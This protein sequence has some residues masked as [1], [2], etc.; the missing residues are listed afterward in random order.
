MHRS[1]QY[2]QT[3]S[4]YFHLFHWGKPQFHFGQADVNMEITFNDSFT[5]DERRDLSL[6]ARDV[7][8]V[9][10]K[11][12]PG[13]PP[14]GIRPISVYRESGNPRVVWPPRSVDRYDIGLHVVGRQYF[15]L[16]YQLGHELGHIMLDPSNSNGALEIL[17]T[18]V[19]LQTLLNME[20]KWQTSPPLQSWRNSAQEFRNYFDETGRSLLGRLGENVGDAVRRE[21]WDFVAQEL[22][23][24]RQ[25]LDEDPC[26]RELNHLGARYLLAHNLPWQEI[27]GTGLVLGA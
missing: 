12:I 9:V 5:D 24:Q 19:A 17:A 10:T 21:K 7:V 14:Q 11:L 8:T 3:V 13:I 2:A 6:V 20:Q 26:N 15:R 25:A 1:V 23:R 27:S 16:A 4:R 18:A 22:R